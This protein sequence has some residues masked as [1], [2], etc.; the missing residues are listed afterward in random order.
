MKKC[1]G[2]EETLTEEI[3]RLTE[4]YS[5]AQKRRT[6]APE[7]KKIRIFF[8]LWFELLV[9]FFSFFFFLHTCRSAELLQHCLAVS[10]SYFLLASW[11]LPG[12]QVW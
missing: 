5:C 4:A 10:C 9:I 7:K 3:R 11:F 12:S 8:K 2:G 1:L 6:R